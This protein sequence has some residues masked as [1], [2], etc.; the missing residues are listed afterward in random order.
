MDLGH[1]CTWHGG[2]TVGMQFGHDMLCGIADTMELQAVG[3]VQYI[4]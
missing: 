1:D 4:I 2:Y 3:T